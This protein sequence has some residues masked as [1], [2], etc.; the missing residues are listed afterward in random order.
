MNAT[1][2]PATPFQEGKAVFEHLADGYHLYVDGG[3]HG[4]FGWG[5]DCPDATITD[6][7]VDGKLPEQ[8]E[9]VCEDW[10]EAVIRSYEPRILQKASDYPDP[11]EI[12][13]AIDGEIL[14]QPEYFY[15]TFEGDTSVACPFGGSFTFGP[16]EIGEAFTFEGCAYT[17]GFAL[18]GS[19][20][21]DYENGLFTIDAQ[22][23][24]DKSGMLTYTS[25]AS[26]GSIS[27]TG[28]YGGET[29]DLSD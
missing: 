18:T 21:Y 6:F 7:M 9:I 13:W 26:D 3:R 1:L 12:F 10:G 5:F 16:N 11:L 17:Q 2:D 4:I 24:G 20:G 8:R 22:V 29:I 27:V 14:L 25:N 19:G 23:S 15:S 28:T